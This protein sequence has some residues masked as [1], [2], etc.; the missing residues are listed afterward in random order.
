[1]YCYTV[2]D[3]DNIQ[4]ALEGNKDSLFYDADSERQGESISWDT[5]GE[6]FYTV[7]EGMYKDIWYYENDI[8]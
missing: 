7:S 6:G 8:V 2:G 1:M 4:T 3:N 5:D